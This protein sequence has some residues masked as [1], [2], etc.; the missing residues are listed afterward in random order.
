MQKALDYLK[1]NRDAQGCW[2][3]FM[4]SAGQS[5][6]WVTAYTGLFLAETKQ[7][8]KLAHEAFDASFFLPMS[9]NDNIL[10]DGDS[11]N[12]AMGL[13]HKVWG[14]TNQSQITNWLAFMDADGGWVTYRDENMLRKRLALPPNVSAEAW[15]TPKSCVTAAAAY[16]LKSYKELAAEY[17]S[18]CAYLAKHQQPEGY[19]LS[20]WWT[21]PIYATAFAVLA[22]GTSRIHAQ[23]REAGL[24]WLAAQQDVTGA[25]LDATSNERPS[26]FFTALA[27]KALLTDTTGAYTSGIENGI[28]WLL[29]HQTT[30]GS[31]V[32]SRILRIPATD[33]EITASVLEW[34][35][36]SFGVN[37]LV[38]DH[39]R[40]FTTST[41]LNALSLFAKVEVGVTQN[42]E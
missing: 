37:I 40:I 22:F 25:W 23:C 4:T 33:V 10:Q 17:E 31:W 28:R 5:I 12:F 9:Y 41:V 15:L 34:R 35:T 36:S 29:A 20:Y 7:G 11:T 3:D 6:L 42:C 18:S 21:S 2:T 27:I 16:V 32:A 1:C 19:W 13:R 30:D 38:D 26:A 8:L 39:N 14:E 24:R